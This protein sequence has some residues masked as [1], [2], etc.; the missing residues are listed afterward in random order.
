M[1]K[2]DD[3]K[4]ASNGGLKEATP[5]RIKDSGYTTSDGTSETI[6]E[7]PI[8][9]WENYWRAMVYKNLDVLLDGSKVSLGSG[10][11]SVDQGDNCVAIGVK[12]AQNSQGDNGIIISSKGS[13]V[14]DTTEGHIHIISSKGSL[15]YTSADGWSTNGGKLKVN[16]DLEVTGDM[17]AGQSPSSSIPLPEGANLDDYTTT[18]FYYQDSNVRATSGSNYPVDHAG[19]LLVEK[20][21]GITQTYKTYGVYNDT[22]Q[23]GYYNGD[24]SSWSKLNYTINVES[25][26]VV[27]N[28]PNVASPATFRLTRIGN[29]CS[30]QALGLVVAAERDSELNLYNLIPLD[31][32][33]PQT[34]DFYGYPNMYY[35]N[36]ET[37]EMAIAMTDG[38]LRLKRFGSGSS[39]TMQFWDTPNVTWF[40]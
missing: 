20:S 32:L 25:Y 33:E 22:Y 39:K 3:I 11:G 5:L 28:Q 26:E 14:D 4:W 35:G 17:P 30:V 18:G 37:Y 21:A 12:A 9:Q 6:P 7:H 31:W 16:G 8:L 24:W 23:R 40:L 34:D 38:E 13:A 2:L 27:Y 1:A 10:S 15:D 36:Y 19:S 29:M